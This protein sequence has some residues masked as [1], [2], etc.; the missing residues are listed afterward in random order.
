MT[1]VAKPR[2]GLL[3]TC[4]VDL[5]RPTVGFAA[6]A[7]L[8]SAG[9][10]VHLPTQ[11]CCGQPAYNGGDRRR[12]VAIARDVIQRFETFD[13]VVAPSGSCAGMLRQYPLLFEEHDPWHARARSLA[14]RA[15]EVTSFLVDVLGYEARPTSRNGVVAYH[16]ACAGLRELGV[17]RQPRRLL[18]QAGMEVSELADAEVC[19]GFGGTFCVKY[20]EISTAMSTQKVASIAASGAKI[21]A[22]GDMGCLLNLAGALSRQRVAVEVRHVVELLQP[23][24]TP[25]IG[26]GDG[27]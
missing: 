20:P 22:A 25:A 10:E 15:F 3:V 12:A 8:E 5:F 6:I 11:T 24:G 23:G 14:E 1:S 26:A 7:L 13:Y 16:D 2:V 19:C 4:L 21:L 18:E 17:E 27:D 9:C